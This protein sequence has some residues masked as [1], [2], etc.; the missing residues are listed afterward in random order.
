MAEYP[1]HDSS[2]ETV[3]F[4]LTSLHHHRGLMK[5]RNSNDCTATFR[6]VKP[7]RRH[8]DS[9]YP[10]FVLSAIYQHLDL[11]QLL[12][13]RRSLHHV[14]RWS[15]TL[16]RDCQVA[17]LRTLAKLAESAY[18][19]NVSAWILYLPWEFCNLATFS[20]APPPFYYLFTV[21][22][23]SNGPHIH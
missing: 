10:L 22:T 20:L 9:T 11:A 13:S 23:S 1:N 18:P 8:R 6:C 17:I 21:A 3:P 14:F 7:R 2:H 12:F 19:R 15:M 5:L 16:W 4:S